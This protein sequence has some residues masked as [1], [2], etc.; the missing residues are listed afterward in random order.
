MYMLVFVK[1]GIS[2]RCVCVFFLLLFSSSGHQFINKVSI[3]EDS[4][5]NYPWIII[6]SHALWVWIWKR[7]SK[8]KRFQVVAT[9]PTQPIYYY[10]Y[11][12]FVTLHDIQLIFGSRFVMVKRIS[13]WLCPQHNLC[14]PFKLL[15]EILYSAWKISLK[16]FVDFF[17]FWITRRFGAETRNLPKPETT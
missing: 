6:S 3:N 17:F 10:V 12:C 1:L 5:A 9:T 11:Y 15:V 14:F 8:S 2:F 16:L 7:K 4:D 13:F